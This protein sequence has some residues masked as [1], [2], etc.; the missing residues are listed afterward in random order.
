[1][2]LS[3]ALP[4]NSEV[5]FVCFCAGP[6]K[7]SLSR[8]IDVHRY[9]FIIGV[10]VSMCKAFIIV[11]ICG[12]PN[13]LIFHES[14]I[15]ESLAARKLLHFS[16]HGGDPFVHGTWLAVAVHDCTCKSFRQTV[17]E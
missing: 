12:G 9:Y 4:L 2:A 11:I 15:D 10:A 14:W 16:L 5:I 8:G 17:G 13:P 6:S 3:F 1:V 7:I